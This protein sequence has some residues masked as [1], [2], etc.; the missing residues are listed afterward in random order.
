MKKNTGGFDEVIRLIIA[1]ALVAYAAFAGPWW[2]GLFAIVPA[3]TAFMSWCPIYD[4]FGINTQWKTV[5]RS[6]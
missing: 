5:N 1:F 3:A 4:M 6:H 2:I